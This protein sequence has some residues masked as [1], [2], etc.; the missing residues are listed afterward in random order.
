[1]K[2]VPKQC[3][4]CPFRPDS[5]PMYLGNYTP[6]EVFRAVWKG[7]PFFCHTTINYSKADWEEK[8]MA[9][10]KLCTGGLLF[11]HKIL[12]PEAEIQHEQIRSARL[13]VLEIEDQMSC[14]TGREFADHHNDENRAKW[15]TQP[16][17]QIKIPK[18]IGKR[19][20]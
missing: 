19:R 20:R 13:K 7:A 5:L 14:M 15:W 8:A 3:D 2:Y 11:A 12:A 1:M 18:S 10:G 16:A 9:K 4:E 6:A 17:G